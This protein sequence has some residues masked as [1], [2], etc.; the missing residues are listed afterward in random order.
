MGQEYLEN[1]PLDSITL[2]IQTKAG[3]EFSPKVKAEFEPRAR[4]ETDLS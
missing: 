3:L 1:A 2:H 4:V